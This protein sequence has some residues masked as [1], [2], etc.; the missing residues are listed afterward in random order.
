V[1]GL[2]FAVKLLPPRK[3]GTEQRTEKKEEWH[4]Q[5][6][7]VVQRCPLFQSRA[8][9]G[10]VRCFL[11][12]SR[13]DTRMKRNPRVGHW[14]L[15]VFQYAVMSRLVIHPLHAEEDRFDWSGAKELSPGVRYV[16][17]ETELPRKMVTNCLQIDSQAPGIKFLSTPRR[18]GW[19]LGKSETNRQTVR[20]FIRSS[21]N[22]RCKLVAAVNGDAFSP[23]PAPYQNEDPTDL[24]GLAITNG[25]IV[26]KSTGTPSL[27]V[28]KRGTLTFATMSPDDDLSEIETAISGFGWCL[29]DGQ[30]P[31]S[32]DERH[33]RTGFGLSQDARYLFLLT[34]DGRQPNSIG[35]TTHD[36][37]QL[38]KMFGAHVGIN[39]DG[40]GST[41]MAWWNQDA[42]EADKCQL[43]NIPVGA[44]RVPTLAQTVA[45]L[46][47][48]ERA[49]GNNFGIYYLAP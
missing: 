7:W 28:M 4:R 32:G 13:R 37:G 39:M 46:V 30:A 14:I 34:I 1:S 16:H 19:E 15:F 26:S 18:K 41:T 23:W 38:L 5:A 25:E 6:L 48:T 47:A 21:R 11:E 22:T 45:P 24:S 9:I 12:V 43:L 40:G 29:V 10:S 2:R 49:N 20:N 33:P 27:L 44:G 36:L 3:A 31:A 42:A 8:L 35:A 17:F